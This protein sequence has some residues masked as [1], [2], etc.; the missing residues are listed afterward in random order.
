MS[1]DANTGR[2]RV[3]VVIPCYNAAEFLPDTLQSAFD[4]TLRELEVIVVD[5]GSTDESAAVA[6]SVAAA[7]EIPVRVLTIPNSGGPATPRNVGAQAALADLVLCIDADDQ[8]TPTFLEL[9]VGMLDE[10][11]EVSIAY[12]DQQDFGAS[13][14]L[15]SVPEY[16]FR[17]LTRRNIFGNCSVFRKQAWIDS[18]GFDPAMLYEDWYFFLSCGIR[19]H[20]GRKVHEV[21]WRYRVSDQGLY[22]TE[23][24]PKDRATKAQIVQRLP[25]LY[26]AQQQAWAA[27]VLA[28][29][30]AADQIPN[31]VG[32][33]PDFAPPPAP[34]AIDTATL[35]AVQP[36][37]A[38]P[39]PEVSV[40]PVA[41]AVS[42]VV[43][44]Y[45]H[46]QFLPEALDSALAQRGLDGPVEV[47]VVDDG[48]Q[49]ETPAVLAAYGDRIR[50]V[51]QENM[52]V[53]K[54]VNRGLSMVTGEYVALLDS[55]DTWPLDR[56]ARHVAALRYNPRVGLVH[57]DMVVTNVHGDIVNPSFFATLKMAPGEGR[58]LGKLL[59]DNF[60]SGGAATFRRSLMAAWHPFPD[61][62]VHQDWWIAATIACVAEI[63]SVTGV[64][65]NYRL[66]G[67]NQ[68]LGVSDERYPHVVRGELPWRRRLLRDFAADPT[69]TAADIL[70]A[71]T[72]LQDGIRAASPLSPTGARGILETDS[73]AAARTLA[74]LPRAAVGAPRSKA[75]IR[76]FAEDPFDAAVWLDLD[77][78]LQHEHLL[79]PLAVPAPLCDLSDVGPL[80]LAW[81]EELAAN[82][83]LL[84]E[85]GVDAK[86]GGSHELAVLTPHTADIAALIRVVE[87][88]EHAS[89]AD[90]AVRVISDPVTPAAQALLASIAGSYLSC[91][92][93]PSPYTGLPPHPAAERVAAA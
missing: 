49:D 67:G 66:H 85:F 17:T 21:N 29:N 25:G 14:T 38:E 64:A 27:M 69:V 50:A 28:G 61:D 53:A 59:A 54:A 34:G 72:T 20:F 83:A 65:N 52:G 56:L 6:G 30:A 60:V 23:Y 46:A 86:A 15:H 55:D 9:C 2:P 16:D 62:I 82:P 74:E 37:S 4:Q 44:A 48:S 7:S 68:G 87:N 33:I 47:I 92:A 36:Q 70:H 89:G 84:R 26:D 79:G 57:G 1:T 75:L 5:D 88:D 18:G 43:A 13:T 77:R 35:L 24:L 91:A 40:T 42:I 73:A 10:H 31:T 39:S 93:P 8:L 63:R 80:T 41:P 76:A 71:R 78:V 90:V 19:G 22:M 12:T 11:P 3:S 51:R 45:N 32:L 81:H 58:V